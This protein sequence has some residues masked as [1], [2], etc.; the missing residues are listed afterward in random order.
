MDLLF[1]T[2]KLFL[3]YDGALSLGSAIVLTIDS[4]LSS[5]CD[6]Y[7]W[8]PHSTFKSLLYSE[9]STDTLSLDIY[10][11]P[12]HCEGFI[13]TINEK[14]LS[15]GC[16]HAAGLYYASKCIQQLS[17]LH[18][19]SLPFCY[20]EDEPALPT[21]GVLIDIGRN[22]IPTM[23]TLYSMID[24]LSDMR[25]NHL[26][27]Y[28]EG[29]CF[30]Y[31]TY[32]YLFSDD[33][34]LTAEE[35]SDLSNYAKAHFIDF[36]P[37]QNI[38]GHM[39]EWLA[40]APLKHLAE[41][42][43]GFTFAGLYWRPPMTLNPTDSESYSF[44]TSLLSPLIK[45][46]S[47]AFIN[48]N[49][50]EPFELGMGK[51]KN[52]VAK[53]GKDQLYF[54]FIFKLNNYCKAN[55]RIMMIWGDQIL[56]Q[57]DLLQKIPENII[58]LDWI[59]E[60]DATFNDHAKKLEESNIDYFL[61]PGTSAWGSFTGRTD[62][63]KK[64]ILDAVSC[65]ICYHAKGIIT[66]DWGDLGHWQYLPFSYPGF[67]YSAYYS[68]TGINDSS[69]ADPCIENFCNH[70]IFPDEGFYPIIHD[71][72]NYYHYEH[73]PLYNT[74]LSFAV[75]SSKYPYDSIESFDAC[76]NRLL[77]LSANIAAENNITQENSSIDFDYSGL[78]DFLNLQHSRLLDIDTHSSE[79]HQLLSSEIANAIRFIKHGATVYHTL[80]ALRSDEKL[81]K[82]SMRN[83]YDDLNDI[84]Q[85]HYQLWTSRNRRGGFSK[86]SA[87]MLHLLDFY[88]A[89]SM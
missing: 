32:R 28:M 64:N 29:F 55:D 20:V 89:M 10:R 88:R 72:G 30:D 73:A 33:T 46:T 45:S 11:T 13:L 85:T 24:H 59:Y 70:S 53:I 3:D 5:E 86:S 80:T 63:M 58:L 23:E 52:V 54:D 1:P 51:S 34:P 8:D 17:M 67:A 15:I 68:W 77:T 12:L 65:A 61:C 36:V 48:V 22:K 66:T 62:N 42:E 14:G 41:C 60:G 87:H 57:P 38:L 81:F 21:R 40:K 7:G 82:Q 78:M 35:L 26:Q 37:N 9:L 50:D 47:S 6:M 43:E 49:L 69:I 2:P 39:N 71:L 84:L 83:L 16:S 56:H 75:I 18:S 76:I 74:T 19:V 44:A 27:L 25:I 4:V 79:N 31:P